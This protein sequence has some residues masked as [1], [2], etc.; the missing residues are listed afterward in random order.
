[1]P[2]GFCGLCKF[3]VLMIF[4]AW[5]NTVAQGFEKSANYWKM[6]CSNTVEVLLNKE[7]NPKPLQCDSVVNSRGLWLNWAVQ[8]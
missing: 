2:V 4:N 7:L 5:G 3:C 6:A 8:L 1:M